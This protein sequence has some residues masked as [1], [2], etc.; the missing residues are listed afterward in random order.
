MKNY[1]QTGGTSVME[2]EKSQ[3]TEVNFPSG[4][5]TFKQLEELNTDVS[6]Q[7]LRSRLKRAVETGTVALSQE[8][9]ATGRRG[10]AQHL[11]FTN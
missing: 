10:R 9:M 4:N 7:T 8:V 2:V 3:K 11:Y 1:N 5:F 6:S